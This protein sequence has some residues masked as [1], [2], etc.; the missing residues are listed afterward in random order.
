M[1]SYGENSGEHHGQL[2]QRCHYNVREDEL[3]LEVM[4]S[5]KQSELCLFNDFRRDQVLSSSEEAVIPVT[6]PTISKLLLDRS[7]YRSSRD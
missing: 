2:R 4:D 5:A 7:K 3:D 1:P 6:E